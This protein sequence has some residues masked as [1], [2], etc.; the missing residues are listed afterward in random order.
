MRVERDQRQ[1]RLQ[2][3]RR[4]GI[5]GPPGLFQLQ[6][7]FRDA[8]ADS[9]GGCLLHLQIER[10]VNPVT[11][12]KQVVFGELRKQLIFHQVD[13]A[14]S[15]NALHIAQHH[16]QWS[17][18][19]FFRFG[20]REHTQIQ[21]ASEHKV[22]ALQGP[23]GILVGRVDV[24]PANHPGEQGGLRD[25]EAA[26]ILVEVSSR[27]LAESVNGKTPALAQ[28]DLVRVQFKNLFL[29]QALLQQEGQKGFRY[30]TADPALRGKPENA[31]RQL[32]GEGTAALYDFFAPEKVVR[33]GSEDAVKV[34]SVMREKAVIFRRQDG[35]NHRLGKV[36]V[37]HQPPFGA[38]IVKQRGDDFRFKLVALERSP[39]GKWGDGGDVP[40]GELQRCRALLDDLTLEK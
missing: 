29:G 23:R 17:P 8:R 2:R 34:H 11:L 26:D 31:P 27:R 40:V 25:V 20:G 39:A 30:F 9:L 21:H 3:I 15:L 6:I 16:A 10:G 12:R 18:A 35:V 1:L 36:L 19:G 22:A 38:G 4:R 24:R 37:A 7:H 14:R 32:H 13:E 28:V 5:L 33:G